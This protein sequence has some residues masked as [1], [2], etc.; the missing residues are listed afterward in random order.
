[1][2]TF[3]VYSHTDFLDILK[4]QTY[5]L[6]SQISINNTYNNKVL[7]INHSDK[8][9]SDISPYY[10]RIIFYDDTLPYASRLCELNALQDEHILFVHDID[11]IV[12]YNND[13][14]N[15]LY[16]VMKDKELDR[17]DL[18]YYPLFIENEIKVKNE[19]G[20]HLV[21][22]QG[23]YRYNVNASIWK[24][25][26][27]LE[28]MTQFNQYSYRQIEEPEVQNFCKKYRI[29]TFT[30]DSYINCGHFGCM[31]FFQ[32]IHLTHGGKLLGKTTNLNDLGPY[33]NLHS[34]LQPVYH[35]ILEDFDLLSSRTMDMRYY[36]PDYYHGPLKK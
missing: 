8:D 32:Y 23:S 19:Y 14:L 15:K 24:V 4:V 16:S 5:Y 34:T 26:S 3:V 11:V 27:F 29:F 33:Q 18:K 31:P 17:I 12:K 35:S 22:S 7:L 2:L 13:E 25:S 9:I 1:M 10:D 30:A 6:N 36:G 28:I 21:P 20:Y